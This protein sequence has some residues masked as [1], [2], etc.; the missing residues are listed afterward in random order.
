MHKSALVLLLLFVLLG[1]VE[2]EEWFMP[3]SNLINEQ[4]FV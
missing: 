3:D 1:L 2:S 4:E